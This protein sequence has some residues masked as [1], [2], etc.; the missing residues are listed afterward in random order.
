MRRRSV[1]DASS[2]RSSSASRSRRPW[3]SR[4][5]SER[6]SGRLTSC[7]R[8]RPPSS[9]GAK[10][11]PSRRALADTESTRWLGLEEQPPAAGPVD[12]QVNL[13]Q[14]GRVALEEVLRPRQVADLGL[15]AAVAQNGPLGRAERKALADEP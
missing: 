14:L 5:T 13:E 11:R 9:A 8:S 7:S 12:A 1:C 15:R 4:R 3:S 6:A 2:A 10:A